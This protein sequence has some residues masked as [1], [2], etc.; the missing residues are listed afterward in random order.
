MTSWPVP[1]LSADIC[2]AGRADAPLSSDNDNPAAAAPSTGTAFLRRLR[3]DECLVCGT[4]A[5]FQYPAMDSLQDSDEERIAQ[6]V[7]VMMVQ[8]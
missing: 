2:A 1:T 8:V 6:L 3:F 7:S 5:T 4:E